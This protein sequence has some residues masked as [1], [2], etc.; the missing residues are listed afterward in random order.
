M[1]IALVLKKYSLEKGGLERYTVSLSRGLLRA[2]HEVHVFA[3]T[4]QQEP[5]MVFHHVPII[6]LSSPVKNLSFAYFSSQALS[7]IKFDVIHSMER[8]FHQDI[9][10]VSDGIN[11]IQI[12][13]NYPN[14]F[15]RK[16]KEMGPRRLALHYLERRIFQRN[17][18]MFIMTNSKLVKGHIIE[19]YNVPSEKIHVIYNGIDTVKFNPEVKEKYRA[20]VREKHAIQNKELS[21]FFVSNDFKLKRLQLILNA[22]LLLGKRNIKL[23]VAGNDNKK[24]YLKWAATNGLENQLIFLGHQKDIEKYYAAS[25][26]FVLPTRYDACANVCIESMA[27]GVPVITTKTNGACEL[28]ENGHNG[29]IL[30]T[31]NAEE[32]ASRIESLEVS[33]ERSRM[34]QNGASIASR[35]TMGKHLSEVLNLYDMVR[36]EDND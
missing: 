21:L 18:S 17:G 6:R 7:K 34:G 4:W 24:P 5:G 26:V 8:I 1:K 14:P 15:V 25:D 22:M 10:R 13:Q 23:M 36:K 2:G 28:I 31:Q 32:L 35:F 11:P 20:V 27:C 30:E 16:F 12:L 33:S 3:N 9:F 19:H 29:Y